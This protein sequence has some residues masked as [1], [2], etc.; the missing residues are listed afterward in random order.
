MEETLEIGNKA[1]SYAQRL[2]ADEAEIFLY[3]ENRTSVKFVG[4]IF[5]S[6]DKAVKGIKGTITRMAESLIK[7]KG[8]PM[9]TSGVRAGVGVRAIINKAIGFSSVSSINEEKVLEAVK[10]AVKIAKIRPPDPNWASLPEPKKSAIEGG[11]FDKRVRD[12][13]I[14][15]ILDLCVDC[16]TT[17]GDF[18]KRVTQVMATISTASVH[19]GVV[20]TCGVEV[21]DAGTFFTVDVSAKAKSGNEEVS[22]GDF[23]IS[24]RFIKDLQP[25]AIGASKRTIECL[26]K[27]PL[28]EKYIGPV[29]FENISW[30][31]LLSTIF[32]AG[33]SALNV[34]ENRSLYRG[35]IGKEVAK[36]E[37]SIMDDGTL[38]EGFGTTKI[39]DEGVP[40]QKTKVIDKGILHSFIYDNYTA[41]REKRESTGNASRQRFFGRA[42]YANQPMIR[43]SNLMLMPNKG[44][45]E[46]LVSELKEGILVKGILIGVHTANVVTGDFSVTANNAFKIENGGIA[47]PLKP[48]TV[49]GNFYQALNSIITI[50]NDLKS[51]GNTVCPSV[52]VE[53][54]V[55]ST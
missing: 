6:R 9:I 5:A 39:D 35:K 18:D 31:Q 23:L 51:F 3:I 21:D 27:K 53:K 33:I 42:A 20:N 14:E 2:G 29:V 45:L 34:Q 19:F 43:P 24:R 30:N 12:L 17:V 8:L 13:K 25:I 44:D 4:G 37:V 1:V 36:K 7:K 15:E 40:R 47:Y 55:V 16:C 38:P 41:R 46:K 28:P 11:V 22:G 26:G 32:A 52:T 48:C 50:G 49:A 54:S 10:E